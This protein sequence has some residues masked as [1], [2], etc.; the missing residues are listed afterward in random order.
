MEDSLHSSM[1][2]ADF[3]H[4]L[5]DSL[6][7]TM[8]TSTSMGDLDVAGEFHSESLKT[9]SHKQLTKSNTMK[10]VYARN[11]IGEGDHINHI[12]QMM[13]YNEL[14]ASQKKTMKDF[15][16]SSNYSAAAELRDRIV[17]LEEEVGDLQRKQ[18]QAQ[19]QKEHRSLTQAAKIIKMNANHYWAEQK[20]RDDE[21][22][23]ESKRD[24]HAAHAVIT[25]NL[26]N[27]LDHFP[28]KIFK[29]STTLLNMR[30]S[31]KSL[32][33]GLRFEEAK[34][35][36]TRADRQ[37]H[38]ERTEFNRVYKT[39]K[40]KKRQ[41]MRDWQQ[42]KVREHDS[43]EKGI[44]WNHKRHADLDKQ[45]TSW[46][47]QQNAQNMMHSHLSESRQKPVHTF[48][49]LNPPRQGHR[50][51]GASN[52]GTQVLA[53]VAKGRAAVA[54]LT[55]IV[56]FGS[57]MVEGTVKYAGRADPFSFSSNVE[58]PISTTQSFRL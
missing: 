56:D 2:A 42:R 39:E 49:E 21:E 41:D 23:Q 35:V 36:K 51:T 47:L 19:H 27:E 12:D 43:L 22:Y 1:T 14:M 50:A 40:E 16:A 58:R 57:P 6:D 8:T 4:S 5:G 25:F 45:R 31:E 26:E 44:E 53:R 3:M 48:K 17:R 52:R 29:S 13:M 33:E 24:M 32:C 34:V 46:R 9:L 20:M 55:A 30:K 54:G 38:K 7:Q 18:R 11:G 28:Q 37:E 10:E 15:I